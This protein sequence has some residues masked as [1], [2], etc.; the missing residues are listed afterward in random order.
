[1][2]KYSR[3]GVD[4]LRSKEESTYTFHRRPP[5][6]PSPSLSFGARNNHP[7]TYIG[8]SNLSLLNKQP[9]YYRC[10]SCLQIFH[11]LAEFS[12]GGGS[13]P[14]IFCFQV[15][16]RVH[17]NGSVCHNR[18]YSCRLSKDGP[19]GVLSSFTISTFQN[20]MK[21][22]LVYAQHSRGACFETP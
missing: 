5:S 17:E 10:R 18:N 9:H 1:M 3:F 2:V 16:C 12:Q 22:T 6:P 4:S 21:S 15:V 14:P 13:I 19:R 11:F 20:L 7:R 8:Q